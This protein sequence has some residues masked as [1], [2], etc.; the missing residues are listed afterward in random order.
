MATLPERERRVLEERF[1]LV[2]GEGR[3]LEEIGGLVGV[4]RERVRQLEQQGLLRLA[5]LADP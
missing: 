5:A 1:G 4:T 3:T 2:G